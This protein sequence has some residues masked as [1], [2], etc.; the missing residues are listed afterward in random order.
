MWVQRRGHWRVL[1]FTCA[2]ILNTRFRPLL[3]CVLR[4]LAG[5][6]DCSALLLLER[7]SETTMSAVCLLWQ[8]SHP[9]LGRTTTTWP[10]CALA[11]RRCRPVRRIPIRGIQRPAATRRAPGGRSLLRTGKVAVAT[12]G[13]R[14][15]DQGWSKAC[16][17]AGLPCPVGQVKLKVHSPT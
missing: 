9:D 1:P 17:V 15:C 5:M 11:W 2:T 4:V 7:C 8:G 16:R 3:T 14:T 10:Q 12:V 13:V 6:M